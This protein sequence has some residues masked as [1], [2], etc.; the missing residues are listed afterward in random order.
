MLTF[1]YMI[2]KIIN[3]QNK[4]SNKKETFINQE[5]ALENFH[6]NDIIF[7]IF[8]LIISMFSVII[9]GMV[10]Y[11]CNKYSNGF[12]R[13]FAVLLAIIFS[14]IYVYYYLIRYVIMEESCFPPII[15]NIKQNNTSLNRMKFQNK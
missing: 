11:K 12:F 13:F 1:G 4:N 7:V 8:L 3:K 5:S 10:A 9:S 6:W 15:K 14:D 2:H